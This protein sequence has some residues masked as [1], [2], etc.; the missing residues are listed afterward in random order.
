MQDAN[1][2]SILLLLVIGTLIYCT[3]CNLLIKGKK[4]LVLSDNEGGYTLSSSISSKNDNYIKVYGKVFDVK[5]KTPIEG[6]IVKFMCQEALVDSS[7]MYTLNILRPVNISYYIN[8][9]SIGYKT[10]RTNEIEFDQVGVIELDFYLEE[11][12]LTTFDC[13]TK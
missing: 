8:C 6:S 9:S 10:V 7:G 13:L 12:I 3:S 4:D 5:S 11:E 2:K 1:L